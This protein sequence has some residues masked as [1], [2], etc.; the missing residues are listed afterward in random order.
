M[1]GDAEKTSEDNCITTVLDVLTDSHFVG[2]WTYRPHGGERQFCASVMV[3]GVTSETRMYDDWK[4][5][6]WEAA[7][8]LAGEIPIA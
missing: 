5:A 3:D 8:I 4:S 6:L 7:S 2:L 1:M